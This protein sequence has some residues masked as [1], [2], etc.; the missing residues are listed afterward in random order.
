MRDSHP[1]HAGDLYYNAFIDLFFHQYYDVL[2]SNKI[3]AL[4]YREKDIADEWT[5]TMLHQ[6][7]TEECMKEFIPGQCYRLSEVKS[8]LQSIYDRLGITQK[9]KANDITLYIP[10]AQ[11]R[12]LTTSSTG[13]RELYCVV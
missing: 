13:K 4:R 6:R 12:Q 3:R 11:Q 9:A 7:I 1:E 5:A 8:M 10:G 2:G